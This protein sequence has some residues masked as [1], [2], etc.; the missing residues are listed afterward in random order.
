M[1]DA[2]GREYALRELRGFGRVAVVAGNEKFVQKALESKSALADALRAVSVAAVG[3]PLEPAQGNDKERG[4]RPHGKSDEGQR[5][6]DHSD[7]IPTD[8]DRWKRWVRRQFQESG[9]EWEEAG[10]A[11]FF[12]GVSGAVTRSGSGE[13]SWY[14]FTQLSSASSLRAR[15]TGE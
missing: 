7:L 11:Y 1:K 2:Q 5:K 9:Q 6:M 15:L 8:V 14:Q 4:F 3:V 13:P 10:G 12:I